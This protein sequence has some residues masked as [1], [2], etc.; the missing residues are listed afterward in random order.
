MKQITS[1]AIFFL[2]IH[3]TFSQSNVVHNRAKNTFAEFSDI[4]A[5]FNSYET[6][7]GDKVNKINFYSGT[8][9]YMLLVKNTG[10]FRT[11]SV[12]KMKRLSMVIKSIQPDFVVSDIFEKEVLL[13]TKTG[14]VWLP[15]QKTL[16]NYWIDELKK[17]DPVLIFIRTYG[18]WENTSDNKW[19]FTINS[20]NANYYDGLWE[21]ALESFEAKDAAN[22]I[23]CLNT[24]IAIDPKD[25]RNYAMYGYYYYDKGFPNDT[26]LLKKADS[27]YNLSIKLTPDFSYAHYQKALTS[28]QLGNYKNAWKHIDKAKELGETRIEKNILN[29]FEEK[30]PY[31]DYLKIKS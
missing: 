11:I 14:T 10:Q 9:G 18:S 23:S 5:H 30:L 12:D 28:F 21:V 25:G 4:A 31:A 17:E 22:G 1:F 19:L 16:Y 26:K 13:Q 29:R 2:L 27:L 8:F 15:I 7:F 3:P 24:L 6:E 20:F